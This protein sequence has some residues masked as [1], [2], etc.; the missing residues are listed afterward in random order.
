MCGPN[1]DPTTYNERGTTMTSAAYAVSESDEIGWP[2]HGL[3]GRENDHYAG[4]K[5]GSCNDCD[6][7][8]QC[9]VCRTPLFLDA[10]R[11]A[12]LCD[13]HRE[14]D[15]SPSCPDCRGMHSDY[16]SDFGH[17]DMDPKTGATILVRH[18]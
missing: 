3:N 15:G 11:Q 1:D 6:A 14:P 12:G 17:L 18:S 8:A 5:P 2:L 10:S 9:R 13:D 4:G 16:R 7:M